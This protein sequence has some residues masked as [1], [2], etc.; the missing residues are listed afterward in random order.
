MAEKPLE[1]VVVL[2]PQGTY[3]ERVAK[4]HWGRRAKYKYA[5]NIS[6]IFKDVSEKKA[7]YGVIPVEDSAEG[8]VTLSLDFLRKNNLYIVKELQLHVTHCL[9]AKKGKEAI[10]IIASHPQALRHCQRYLA[11]NFDKA[12]QRQTSSTA[13]AAR[14]ASTDP[15]IGA[16]AAEGVKTHYH[17]NVISRDVHDRGC[18]TTRF[19]I[20]ARKPVKPKGSVKTSIIVDIPEDRPGVL[21]QILGEFARRG[22][23]LT[24]IISRPSRG[25]LG[26]YVFHID[27]QGSEEDTKVK[28]ALKAIEKVAAVR[29]LGSYSLEVEKP[30]KIGKTTPK[31][32]K[33]QVTME[34]L[35][36]ME[37]SFEFWKNEEDQAYNSY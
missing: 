8:D 23:N 9:L 33:S 30:I 1:N 24:K 35:R 37:P 7:T 18:N 3:T 15:T 26:E 4:K 11:M 31:K 36:L 21:Y 13:E 16:I 12:D 28:N 2:G 20:L 27:F 10:K 14:L 19:F 29:R 5:Y 25:I 22:I 32:V 17:L 6:S 34:D